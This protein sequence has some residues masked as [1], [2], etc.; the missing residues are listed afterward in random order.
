M[1]HDAL[2]NFEM[3]CKTVGVTNESILTAGLN[4]LLMKNL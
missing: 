1:M 3:A 4:K 2:L